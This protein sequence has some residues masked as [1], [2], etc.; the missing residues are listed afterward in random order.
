MPRPRGRARRLAV[1]ALLLG[2]L[3]GLALALE[4]RFLHLGPGGGPEPHLVGGHH[5]DGDARCQLVDQAGLG[6]TLLPA[7]RPLAP[8]QHRGGAVCV[9]VAATPRATPPGAYEARAPP[10]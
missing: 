4:H 8:L 5:H 9:A 3:L 7:L 10:G 1:A 6:D 2:W